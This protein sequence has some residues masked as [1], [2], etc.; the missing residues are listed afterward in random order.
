MSEIL[1]GGSLAEILEQDGQ[2]P[3]TVVR[4]FGADICQGLFHLH[5]NSVVFALLNP[6]AISLDANASAKVQSIV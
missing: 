5:Q 6:A 3:E 2:L 4:D 1:S